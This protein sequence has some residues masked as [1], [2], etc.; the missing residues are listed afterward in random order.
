MSLEPILKLILALL[1][2]YMSYIYLRSLI[3]II[4]RYLR[5]SALLKR[6]SK[7]NFKKLIRQA[8]KQTDNIE[9]SLIEHNFS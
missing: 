7:Y 5:I 8:R 6:N 9:E 4:L 3:Y 1:I 2:T